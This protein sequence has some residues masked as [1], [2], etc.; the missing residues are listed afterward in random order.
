MNAPLSARVEKV[1]RDV[2]ADER[3]VAA[4]D[5]ISRLVK[6]LSYEQDQVLGLDTLL[7][8]AEV[9]RDN[10][11]REL[12]ALRVMVQ[13]YAEANRKLSEE[14]DHYKGECNRL[15]S[16]LCVMTWRRNSLAKQCD[17]FHY[18]Q[19]VREHGES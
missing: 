10:A 12:A 8:N 1:F 6:D 19:F 7:T 4:T 18:E 3:K 17:R 9:E 11:R 15:D 16:E 2:D 14:R 5:V 13:Q